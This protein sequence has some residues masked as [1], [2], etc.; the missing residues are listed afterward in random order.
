MDSIPVHIDNC[1]LCGKQHD[2]VV[3]FDSQVVHYSLKPGWKRESFIQDFEVYLTCP[4]RQSPFRAVIR[5]D[6][7]EKYITEVEEK[8]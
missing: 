5:I 6:T 8:K 7:F 1:P 2:H 4:V 3:Q